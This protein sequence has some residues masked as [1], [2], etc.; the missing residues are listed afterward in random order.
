MKTTHSLVTLLLAIAVNATSTGCT[1]SAEI[2]DDETE[3]PADDGPP[4]E[5]TSPAG[6]YAVRSQFDLATNM[7]GR[8]GEAVNM[9]IAATDDPDDP[10]AW[11]LEQAVAQMDD[12]L[13]KSSLNAIR[14]Y[15]AGYL[16]DRILQVAPNFVATMIQTGN[17]FGEVARRFGLDATLEITA[18]GT[19]WTSTH[20]VAGVHFQ[21]DNIVT[22]VPFAGY[23][24]ADVVVP[25][26]GVTFGETGGLGVAEHRVPLAYGKILR[27]GL[28]GAIIPM[29]DPMAH[30]LGTLFQHQIDC[31]AVGQQIASALSLGLGAETF[32]A[33]C[34]AG[35]AA[36]AKLIYAKIDSINASALE[37][38]LTGTAKALDTN[39]DRRVDKII[40]GSWTGTLSYAG[41]P[42][43]LA[44]ATFSGARMQ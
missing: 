2:E 17:D 42:A 11:L 23:Q 8:V 1:A 32:A 22:V 21:I 5:A 33:G 27:I 9:F 10:A 15:V 12:G 39:D 6:K 41:T 4:P 19:G 28:D 3:P 36:S 43:P 13:L 37:F 16:N 14:P 38:T 7:P 35:L 44:A 31:V 40:S 20:S 26:V 30:D 29:I 34:G 24:V 18:A 25:N